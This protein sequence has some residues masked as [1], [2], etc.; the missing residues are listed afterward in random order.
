MIPVLKPLSSISIGRTGELEGPPKPITAAPVHHQ[1]LPQEN[2]SRG[3]LCYVEGIAMAS[4]RSL[5]LSHQ[6]APTNY[7]PPPD[8][9]HLQ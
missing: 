3:G 2:L 6:S 1:D 8:H 7:K 5:S 4:K 9:R